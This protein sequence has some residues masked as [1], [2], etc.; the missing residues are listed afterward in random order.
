MKKNSVG[1]YKDINTQTGIVDAD[2]HRLIQMLYAGALENISIAKGCIQREDHAGKGVAISKAIGIV[3]GLHDSINQ[4]VLEGGISENLASLYTF[5]TSRLTH[6]NIH[7]EIK[8][9]DESVTV[10]KELQAGWNGIRAEVT[11]QKQAELV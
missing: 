4:D 9:L 6:A 1:Q 8:S 11:K 10:L 3:G 5:V 7:N 2:P